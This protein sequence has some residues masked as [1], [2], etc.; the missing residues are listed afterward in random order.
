MPPSLVASQLSMRELS[1]KIAFNMKLT[2]KGDEFEKIH[3]SGGAYVISLLEAFHV[4]DPPA[5]RPLPLVRD[6][7]VDRSFGWGYTELASQGIVAVHRPWCGFIHH[8]FYEL[9][10]PNNAGALFENPGFLT[11]LSCCIGLF[12]FSQDSATKVRLALQKNKLGHVPVLSLLHPTESS[13]EL[14]TLWNLLSNNN[15]MIVQVGAWLRDPYAI[16]QLPLEDAMKNRDPV[17]MVMKNSLRFWMLRYQQRAINLHKAV[18]EGPQ[19]ASYILPRPLNVSVR[20]LVEEI[21]FDFDDYLKV[22][23]LEPTPPR[24]ISGE[25]PSRHIGPSRGVMSREGQIQ[26]KAVRGMVS[27]LIDTVKGVDILP[28]LSDA[29]YDTL[30]SKNIVFLKLFDASA[31]NTIIECI[32]RNTPVLVNRL[33]ATEE[34][35]GRDYPFFYNT[36]IEAAEKAIAVQAI[37]KTTVYLSKK[38]KRPFEGATFMETLLQWLLNR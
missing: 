12:V 26:N 36:L 38:D 13:N 17:D 25:G 24:P 23:E 1:N 33:P 22:T 20:S 11:S 19:M 32:V 18:L 10:S 30:L 9:Y 34:Y 28:T 14:F 21:D 27:N 31:V 6:V 37:Y 3:R 35:L 4:D 7:Y 8:T 2:C 15:K 29:D 5:G 16:Y